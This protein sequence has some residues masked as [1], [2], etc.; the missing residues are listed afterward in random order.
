[1]TRKRRKE[2]KRE[3][4]RSVMTMALARSARAFLGLSERNLGVKQAAL[5]SSTTSTTT[6]RDAS[7]VSFLIKKSFF[8][9]FAAKDGG[10]GKEEN[11][12]TKSVLSKALDF[13]ATVLD[14]KYL[15]AKVVHPL[16]N[17][18]AQLVGED[19]NGNQ[20]F[21]IKKGVQ[22]GRH[23]W[24]VYKDVHD[25][26]PASVPPEWH[27]WLHNINDDAPSRVSPLPRE[28]YFFYF[29]PL[30]CFC[31]SLPSSLKLEGTKT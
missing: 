24:V 2:K 9:T 17:R 19:Y 25:Y 16:M 6:T 12:T 22:Y 3:E 29:I 4:K 20:Y 28:K 5:V 8:P 11:N 31:L 21:E 10:E 13:A 14:G 30:F 15:E 7:F 26:S 23:R 18:G 1:M 27:G